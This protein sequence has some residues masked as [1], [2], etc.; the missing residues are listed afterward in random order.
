MQRRDQTVAGMGGQ[1]TRVGVEYVGFEVQ[2]RKA[3][4]MNVILKYI[5]C[6]THS[7]CK[8]IENFLFTTLFFYINMHSIA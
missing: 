4:S 5:V 6:G 8:E 1:G 2:S 3:S 7:C